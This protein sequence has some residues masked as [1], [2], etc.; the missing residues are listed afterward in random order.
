MT[1][2]L[3]FSRKQNAIL[4]LIFITTLV[5]SFGIAACSSNVPPNLSPQAKIA[6]V[7]TQVIKS[8]DL[9]RDIT[10]S[11]N[12]QTPPLVSTEDT[13]KVVLYHQSAIKT[14]MAMPAGWKTTVTT[15]LDETI[16]NLS[17]NTQKLLSPYIALA[18]TILAQIP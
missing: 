15:G 13:R 10:I 17:E 18:K 14:I 5:M 2:L 11:A 3:C 16:K 8:L 6:Y 7:N 4:G 12:E 1:Q 9:L